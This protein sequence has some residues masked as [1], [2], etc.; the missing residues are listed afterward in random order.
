MTPERQKELRE[1]GVKY[2]HPASSLIGQ[3]ADYIEVLEQR[4][5]AAKEYREVRDH[6]DANT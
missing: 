5:R 2:G 4:V 1:L 3:A 6:N